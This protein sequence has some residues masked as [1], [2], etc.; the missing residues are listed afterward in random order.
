MRQLGAEQACQILVGTKPWRRPEVDPGL[1]GRIIRPVWPGNASEPL[2]EEEQGVGGEKGK[3][4]TISI[5]YTEEKGLDD[6][7]RCFPPCFQ[8]AAFAEAEGRVGLNT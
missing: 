6:M 4:L 5:G 1:A 2:R 3:S 8:F 7:L